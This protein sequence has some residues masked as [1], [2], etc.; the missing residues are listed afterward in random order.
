MQF[1]M[2]NEALNLVKAVRSSTLFLWKVLRDNCSGKALIIQSF[3]F[4]E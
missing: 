1:K 4:P 3:D 2:G